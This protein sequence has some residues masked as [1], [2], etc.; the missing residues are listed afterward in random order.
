MGW[1]RSEKRRS[2]LSWLAEQRRSCLCWLPEETRCLS[3]LSAKQRCG[4]LCWVWVV[5]TEKRGLTKSIGL[6]GCRLAKQT[7]LLLRLGSEK[8]CSSLLRRLSEQR[9]SL[10]HWSR[11]IAKRWLCSKDALLCG[12]ILSKEAGCGRDVVVGSDSS[13]GRQRSLS[14]EGGANGLEP[15]LIGS[16]AL[17]LKRLLV[18]HGL[19]SSALHKVYPDF[20]FAEACELIQGSDALDQMLSIEFGVLAL[21]WLDGLRA[22]IGNRRRG[23]EGRSRHAPSSPSEFVVVVVVVGI[24]ESIVVGAE[25]AGV[26]WCIGG[27]VVGLAKE[28]I[29]WLGV[30]GR[31]ER[32]EKPSS[33]VWLLLLLVVVAEERVSSS[34]VVVSTKDANVIVVVVSKGIVVG[35]E[36][37]G[38]L[39]LVAEEGVVGVVGRRSE[40][41]ISI[42]LSGSEQSV[43]LCLLSVVVVSKESVSSSVIV[44]SKQ[45]RVVLRLVVSEESLLLLRLLLSSSKQSIIV[46]G[47]VVAKE[48]VVLLRLLVAEKALLCLLVVVSELALLLILVVAEEAIVGI[49]LCVAEESLSWLRGRLSEG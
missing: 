2:S 23:I 31:G 38:L 27:E 22:D 7:R 41:S 11:R 26:G 3:G 47:L 29:G 45:S 35:V 12:L 15:V 28:S 34:V 17:R 24:V 1:L 16:E 40:E 46:A 42:V 37:I 48:T 49:A 36:W 8:R 14:S 5:L 20:F 30:V 9:S 44:G 4:W 10:S 25:D 39:C 43:P 6:S 32:V 18:D 19:L 33:V 13:K 21:D